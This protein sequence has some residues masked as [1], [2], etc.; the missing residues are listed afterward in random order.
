MRACLCVRA[1]CA[2]ATTRS[3]PE[4]T[5]RH[6]KVHSST[7]LNR[8]ASRASARVTSNTS[9]G[10]RRARRRASR[11]EPPPPPTT[12]ATETTTRHARTNRRARRPRRR[13]SRTSRSGRS[14][15][16]RGWSDWRRLRPW[17]PPLR[18][19]RP[20]IRAPGTDG[21]RGGQSPSKRRSSSGAKRPRRVPFPPPDAPSATPHPR[22]TARGHGRVDASQRIGQRGLCDR[23][24]TS[25][26]GPGVARRQRASSMRGTR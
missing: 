24:R 9:R 7:E 5:S 8:P 4:A 3:R 16:V 2:V 26:V 20:T 6:V 17:R 10:P 14:S 15:R 18:R 25:L 1:L 19:P 23:M 13:R 22:R 12:C 11:H 21:G